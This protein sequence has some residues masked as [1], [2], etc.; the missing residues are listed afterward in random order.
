[1]HP[2]SAALMLAAALHGAPTTGEDSPDPRDGVVD[3]GISLSIVARSVPPLRAPLHWALYASAEALPGPF[4]PGEPFRE[5]VVESTGDPTRIEV[6]AVPAGD[7]FAII[8]LDTNRDGDIGR[9]S[10]PRGYS[11]YDGCLVPRWRAGVRAVSERSRSIPVALHCNWNVSES[12][13]GPEP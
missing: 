11:G 8:A 2:S 1:M 7:Y 4:S 3:V 10:E 9:F 12:G 5:G 13:S 6:G